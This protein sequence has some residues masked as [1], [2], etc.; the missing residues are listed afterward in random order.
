MKKQP[1][2][3]FG[4]KVLAKRNNYGIEFRRA[5]DNLYLKTICTKEVRPLIPKLAKLPLNKKVSVQF[6]PIRITKFKA[7]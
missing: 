7:K 4:P 5:E 3:K 2:S 1:K 6:G